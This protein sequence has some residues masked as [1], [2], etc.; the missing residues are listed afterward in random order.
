M[1]FPLVALV[2]SGY[3][4]ASLTCCS[5]LEPCFHQVVRYGLVQFDTGYIGKV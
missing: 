1:Q 2:A 4:K 5:D 3:Q